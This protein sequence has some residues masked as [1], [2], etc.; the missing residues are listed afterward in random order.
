MSCT[1]NKGLSIDVMPLAFHMLMIAMYEKYNDHQS[2]AWYTVHIIS[3]RVEWDIDQ[4]PLAFVHGTVH[5]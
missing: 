3:T 4:E 5:V 2:G 1:K